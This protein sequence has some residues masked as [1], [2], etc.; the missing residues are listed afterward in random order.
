MQLQP[1]GILGKRNT[2]ILL[3]GISCHSWKT[4]FLDK[5]R[6]MR[7]CPTLKTARR[8]RISHRHCS[9]NFIA[10]TSAF[11]FF[12]PPPFLNLLH[13]FPIKIH[14]INLDLFFCP[15]LNFPIK[16]SAQHVHFTASLQPTSLG[17]LSSYS[18]FFQVKALAYIVFFLIVVY[19]TS[20][21][22][23]LLS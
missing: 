4:A 8:S 9:S 20:A 6:E 7:S 10:N 16:Y 23:K 17:F 21:I 18:V 15:L 22:Y 1:R 11:L 2:N 14:E 12:F 3:L 19:E 13:V 5:R